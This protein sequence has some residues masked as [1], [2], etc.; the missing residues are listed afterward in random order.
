MIRFYSI[1][2]HLLFHVPVE[3][4]LISMLTQ[5]TILAHQ[6]ADYCEH[7]PAISLLFNSAIMACWLLDTSHCQRRC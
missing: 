3:G 7:Q 4:A 2:E 1:L 5:Y 6:N